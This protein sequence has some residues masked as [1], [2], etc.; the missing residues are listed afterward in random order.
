MLLH[1]HKKFNSLFSIGGCLEIRKL[2]E[3]T[4]LREVYEECG[5]DVELYN[6]QKQLG[7]TRVWQLINPQY[8]LLEN[9]GREV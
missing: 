5:L 3:Q 2:P 8:T 1:I 6:P 4:A 7:M 9:I